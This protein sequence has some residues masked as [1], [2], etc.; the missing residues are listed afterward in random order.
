VLKILDKRPMTDPVSLWS[1]FIQ[2]ER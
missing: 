1:T 2:K